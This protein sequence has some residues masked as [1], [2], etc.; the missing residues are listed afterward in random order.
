MASDLFWHVPRWQASGPEVTLGV[1]NVAD[2]IV[3]E[4]LETE[5]A[6]QNI[7][8]DNYWVERIV[9]QQLL[10]VFRGPNG[11]TPPDVFRH[12]RVYVAAADLG[13]VDLRDLRSPDD[14][15]TSWLMHK[16]SL[17][18]SVN[19]LD[20]PLGTWD[21]F[22]GQ[23]P[24]KYSG[25]ISVPGGFDIRVGRKVTEGMSLVWH[26]QLVSDGTVIDDS[27]F[28]LKMW[29]RVLLRKL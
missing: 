26:D 8:P 9:G 23:V 3:V 20:E 4:L 18:D 16:V 1:Q 28:A 12:T 13:G 24:Q 10:T 14:A 17:I 21:D 11:E 29:C 6:S 2:N 7:E 25:A 5:T 19:Q 27:T 22:Y 15:D